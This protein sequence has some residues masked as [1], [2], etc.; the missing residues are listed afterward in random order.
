MASSRTPRRGT[1]SGGAGRSLP[2]APGSRPLGDATGRDGSVRPRPPAALPSAAFTVEARHD[3][4]GAGAP[5]SDGRP[6]GI[7]G[8]DGTDACLLAAAY[9]TGGDGSLT[10][11]GDKAVVVWEPSRRRLVVARTGFLAGDLVTWSDS[12]FFAFGTEP[13]QVLAV[14]RIAP[15]RIEAGRMD[16]VARRPRLARV[17]H[18]AAGDRITVTAAAEPRRVSRVWQRTAGRADADLPLG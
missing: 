7:A 13:A 6:V 11:L 9:R 3:Q 2:P 12:R 1:S 5:D 15:G 4:A 17:R 14:C 18:L 16:T 8:V 10:G